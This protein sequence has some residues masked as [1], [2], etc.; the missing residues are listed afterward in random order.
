MLGID[1]IGFA[2]N[3]AQGQGQGQGQ[4]QYNKLSAFFVC[5]MFLPMV[6]LQQQAVQEGTMQNNQQGS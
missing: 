5:L 2:H 3:V 6:W 1:C 4:A